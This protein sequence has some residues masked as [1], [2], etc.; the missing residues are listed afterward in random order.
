MKKRIVSALLAVCMI[1]SL[2]VIQSPVTAENSL[3]FTD[4]KGNNWFYEDVLYVYNTGLIIGTSDTT[5]SPKVTVSRAMF[6]TMLGRLA[7]VEPKET[8]AFSDVPKGKWYSGYVGWAHENKIVE[9]TGNGTFNPNGDLTREQ[10]A[11]LATRFI[12][13][14]K[15]NPTMSSTAP[16]YFGDE[17][18]ISK[19]AADA[20][21]EVRKSGII[22]GT[23]TGDFNPKGKLSRAEAA[24]VIRRIKEMIDLLSIKE[25]ISLSYIVEGEDFHLLGAWDLYYAGTGI[26]ASYD[27][28]KVD[29]S[30]TPPLLVENEGGRM[31]AGSHTVLHD[32]EYIGVDLKVLNIDPTEYPYIRFGFE[33]NTEV[34]LKVQNSLKNGNV[35]SVNDGIIADVSGVFSADS[36]EMP[37]LLTADAEADISLKYVTA[38]KTGSE[39]E[40]FEV[41]KYV[42]L[43]AEHDSA[44]VKFLKENKNI[45]QEY[46]DLIDSRIEEIKNFSDDIEPEKYVRNGGNIYYISY[47]SGDD[48][49]SGTS[50]ETPWKTTYNLY[51]FL[52][53][54]DKEII[55]PKTN[56]GDVV[57][58]ERGNVFNLSIKG[59]TNWMDFNQGVTY[60]A[61]GEGDKPLFTAY[62]PIEN[63]VGKWIETSYDNVW[64]LN[65]DLTD[66]G[67]IG[68]IV[69][70]KENTELWGVKII[71]SDP[72]DPYASGSRSQDIGY[73][74]NG[75]TYFYSGSRAFKDPGVLEND[76]EFF[77]DTAACE[78]YVYCKNGS[79]ADVFDDIKLCPKSTIAS[80]SSPAHG[81]N[82]Y[83]TVIDNLA[84]AYAGAHGLACE[85][86]DLYITNCT[87]E[88]I[89]GSIQGGT[90]RFGN[91]VENW[92]DCDGMFVNN[93]YINQVYDAGVTSQG[94]GEMMNIYC[95]NNVIERTGFHFEFFNGNG[96][97]E[98]FENVFLRNNLNRY[99]GYG[100]G[101]TRADKQ[102][103]FLRGH[104]GWEG[105]DV[106][107]F[108]YENNVGIYCAIAAISTGGLARGEHAAGVILR[109]NTYLCNDIAANMLR[110][111]TSIE[112]ESGGD[113][114]MYPYTEQ[115]IQYLADIG[116]ERGSTF[117]YCD[118]FLYDGEELGLFR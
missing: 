76:L 20:V 103:T 43:L 36:Y 26:I 34:T 63:N 8:D 98:K 107:N 99:G 57:L 78:L 46:M 110:S 35:T 48:S 96:E 104:K 92:G 1:M 37:V 85:S 44:E 33:S 87:F 74:T 68:N 101:H 108:V 54:G 59:E 94:S 32:G 70:T 113:K 3:P 86:F 71:P 27:G 52:G 17:E 4:V 10:M 39:A 6:V 93:C 100:F 89:G 58:F 88:W 24:A 14:M 30:S 2:A 79:P 49:N 13:Y 28:T 21:D 15:I 9:G 90:G 31:H 106:Y 117:Y 41:S 91:A 114:V 45:T 73:V 69:F 97:G 61:Y 118:Y 53:S 16:D 11:L 83:N 47:E 112:Y 50:P 111:R 55:F 115:Y 18:Q 82:G 40:S 29:T 67:D 84:F 5:F 72:A 51:R 116:I 42:D 56:P 19:W 60:G 75:E 105:V 38:F 80:V 25:G 62:L 66:I 81:H 95:E 77:H 12:N 64:K 7:G 23:G 109:N 65:Y 22:K 102:G